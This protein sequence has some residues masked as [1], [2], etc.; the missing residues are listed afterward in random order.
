MKRIPLL[1][2]ITFGLILYSCG[3]ADSKNEKESSATETQAAGDLDPTNKE[4]PSAGFELNKE[5]RPQAAARAETESFRGKIPDNN[6]ILSHI[7]QYLV[8]T[9]Q[10]TKGPNGLSNATISIKNNLEA[11]TIRKA[12]VQVT[13]LTADGK[14]VRDDF[15]DIQNLEPGETETIRVPA[16]TGAVSLLAQVVKLKSNELTNGEMILVG[17]HYNPQE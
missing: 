4:A 1:L 17:T 11:I 3:N 10:F 15:F 6:E 9:P 12:I 16:A 5:A 2:I 7:D 14:M 13:A 8:S